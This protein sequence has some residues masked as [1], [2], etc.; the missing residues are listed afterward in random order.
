MIVEDDAGV[1]RMLKMVMDT[2]ADEFCE[3]DNGAEALGLYRRQRPDWVL[4]DVQM[5]RLDGIAATRAIC[6][7]FPEAKIVIVTNYDDDHLRR[8]ARAAGASGYLLK[9]NLLALRALLC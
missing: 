6:A 1:R 9:D 3:C 5:A 4:M 7:S 2:V 8:A